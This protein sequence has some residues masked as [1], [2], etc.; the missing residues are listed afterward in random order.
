MWT[1]G[2]V[3]ELFALLDQLGN[4]FFLEL[5]A[6]LHR[7]MAGHR[8]ESAIETVW[9]AAVH[10]RRRHQR[11]HQIVHGLLPQNS[12]H[13]ANNDRVRAEILDLQ[14]QALKLLLLFESESVQFRRQSNW[15]RNQQP[16]A[17][18]PPR[19]KIVL[20]A[21]IQDAFMKSVLIHKH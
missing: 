16:L 19:R 6:S 10:I 4:L 2:V 5:V 7:S 21:C 18:N 8:E 12:R 1:R 15:V 9:H 11:F 20:K 14:P 13:R 3:L 17:L